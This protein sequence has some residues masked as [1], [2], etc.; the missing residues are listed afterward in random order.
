V[1]LLGTKPVP[2]DEVDNQT[3]GAYGPG[4]TTGVEAPNECTDLTVD[5][6]FF[7]PPAQFG[8]RVWIESNNDGIAATGVITPV[9]GMVI[10]ATDGV[11]VYTTTTTAQGYYSFTVAAGTYTVTY[12]SVPAFYGAVVPRNTP[13]G[14]SASGN[15]GLYEEP[16]NPD[17]SRPQNHLSPPGLGAGG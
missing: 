1:I 13:L 17:Q 14:N 9:A 4:S 12:G 2:L 8:D 5:F 16:G 10:T 6:G 11:N 15:A 7:V 3:P